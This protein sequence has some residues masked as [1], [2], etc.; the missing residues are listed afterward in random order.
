MY[1]FVVAALLLALPGL[2][3]ATDAERGRQKAAVCVACHGADGIAVIAEYP[4]LAGQKV[5]YLQLAIK[6]YRDGERRHAVM[7]PMAA[8]LSEQDIADIAAFYASLSPAGTSSS[9]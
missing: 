2:A 3:W 5:K 7:S 9:K 8:G 4:N 1:K 6:A